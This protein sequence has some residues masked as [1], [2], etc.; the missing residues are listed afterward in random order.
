MHHNHQHG[1][2]S[3]APTTWGRAFALGVSLNLLFVIVEA[4]A[5]VWAQSIALISDAGH[6]LSDVAG[7][8]IAW[9]AIWLAQRTPTPRSTYGYRRA[10]ILASL[11]NAVLLFVAVGGIGWEAVRRLLAPEPV[12]GEMMM[13]VAGVGIVVNGLTAW[14]FAQGQH[15]LNLRGAF[16]HMLAD[17]LVSAG[18]VVAGAL[19]LL[20]DWLWLDPLVSL[21][22]IAVILYGTWSLARQ[23]L[24]LALDGVPPT[25]D[26]SAVQTYL[27]TLPEVSNVHD[28]HIWALS[29]TE[30]ALTV[31]LVTLELVDCDHWLTQVRTTLHERFGIEHTTLQLER[32][33]ARYP[34]GCTLLVDVHG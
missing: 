15:D 26:P 29:T 3:H 7:L 1:H 30:P 10:S 13:A 16:L 31:H 8:L 27:T 9:G 34:C 28:L 17:A 25:I 33:D 18:V 20:T 23:A 14:L 2:H 19:V 4:S 5:G 12:V 22:I 32:G 11:A 24:D 21:L 6:N